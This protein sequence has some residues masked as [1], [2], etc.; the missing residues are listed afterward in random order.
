MRHRELRRAARPAFEEALESAY[1][2]V[3]TQ[4]AEPSVMQAS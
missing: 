3:N 1:L 4:A 2:S